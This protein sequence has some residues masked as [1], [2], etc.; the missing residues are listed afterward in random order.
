MVA[1]VVAVAVGVAVGVVVAVVVAVAVGVGVAVG[2]AVV[3]NDKPGMYQSW[4]EAVLG[5]LAML[6]GI[7]LT[8]AL[9]GVLCYATYEIFV[10]LL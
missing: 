1:V 10:W 3:M 8:A 7:A 4:P 5:V 9:L 6:G 2:V